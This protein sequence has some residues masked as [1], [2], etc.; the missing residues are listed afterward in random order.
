MSAKFPRGG[1]GEG[2]GPFLARSLNIVPLHPTAQ[3]IEL[4]EETD[5][6]ISYCR[7]NQK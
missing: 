2:A 6:Q 7:A 4:S 1:G 3:L 5:G